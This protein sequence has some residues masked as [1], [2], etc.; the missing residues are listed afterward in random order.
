MQHIRYR[1][2]FASRSTLLAGPH[3]LPVLINGDWRIVEYGGF[4]ELPNGKEV[5]VSDVVSFISNNGAVTY[6]GKL[7]RGYLI[8]GRV[9]V[10]LNDSHPVVVPGE[11]YSW[12]KYTDQPKASVTRLF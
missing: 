3:K 1:T 10:Y 8:K 9:C 7:I 11:Q 4:T 2:N 12:P 5:S 6:L